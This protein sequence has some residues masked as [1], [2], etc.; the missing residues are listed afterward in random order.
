MRHNV[1]KVPGN[2]RRE[3]CACVT[4]VMCVMCETQPRPDD[5]IAQPNGNFI[6]SQLS[7]RNQFSNVCVMREMLIVKSFEPIK[8]ITLFMCG[9]SYAMYTNDV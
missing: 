6:F 9:K 1:S 7:A 3:F 5:F 4:C 2:L 8:E